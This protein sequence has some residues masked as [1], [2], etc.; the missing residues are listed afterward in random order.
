MLSAGLQS[1]DNVI[2][3]R[4]AIESVSRRHG[5]IASLLPKPN[6]TSAGS[7]GH[8]HFSIEDSTGKNLMGTLLENLQGEGSPAE[9]FVAGK[10]SL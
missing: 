4:E 1:A 10:I 6:L 2:F 5:L 8:T 9:S 7:G 3:L